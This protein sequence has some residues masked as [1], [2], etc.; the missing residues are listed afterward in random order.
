MSQAFQSFATQERQRDNAVKELRQL[1]AEHTVARAAAKLAANPV[2]ES[3]EC[4]ET[5]VVVE[6]PLSP[7]DNRRL[8]R[9]FALMSGPHGSAIIAVLRMEWPNL[10]D[11][12]PI[13]S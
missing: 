3:A 1:L 9:I 2:D 13:P 12:E 10:L 4:P 5:S 11:G 8:Q 6:P 7:D